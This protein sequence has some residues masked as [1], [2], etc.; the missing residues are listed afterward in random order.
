MAPPWRATP[1]DASPAPA[2]ARKAK[3]AVVPPLVA[4]V[5]LARGSNPWT[6]S[7]RLDPRL[8]GKSGIPAA[9]A[10][11]PMDSPLLI[12][13]TEVHRAILRPA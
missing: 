1:R 10:L 8:E 6:R 7:L 3:A 9:R 13:I 12:P 2:A 4:S 5:P 11:L